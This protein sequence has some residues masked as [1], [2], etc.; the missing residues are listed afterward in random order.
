MTNNYFRPIK[1]VAFKD[2]I[3][4]LL[5]AIIHLTTKKTQKSSI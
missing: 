2:N 5:M 1:I 4:L 3:K